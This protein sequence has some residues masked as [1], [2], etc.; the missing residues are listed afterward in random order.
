LVDNPHGCR[1]RAPYLQR[2]HEIL[3]YQ[4]QEPFNIPQAETRS[5]KDVIELPWGSEIYSLLT[6]WKPARLAPAFPAPPAAGACCRRHGAGRFTV[7]HHL[8][9]DGHSV[10]GI[11]GLR[12]SRCP[13]TSSRSDRTGARVAFEPIFDSESLFESLD[14]RVMA[15][16]GGVANTASRY[17]GTRTS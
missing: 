7:A 2:L 1:H 10:V 13:H 17:A 11:D 12:S 14:D 9:N 16:F 3:I 8:M 5:L 4:K 6:R 15:G